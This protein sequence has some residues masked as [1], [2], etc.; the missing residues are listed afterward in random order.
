[1]CDND[2]T[3]G[4][5]TSGCCQA[6]G[7]CGSCGCGGDQPAQPAGDAPA[8]AS[9]AQAVNPLALALA[10]E[11]QFANACARG[12][13]VEETELLFTPLN[14]EAL[15][16]L[17]V[18]LGVEGCD[19]NV[20]VSAFSDDQEY[21]ALL[22]ALY[23]LAVSEG[24]EA[25]QN[26]RALG[27]I[28]G[29]NDFCS[30]THGNGQG[31]TA[32]LPVPGGEEIGQ[33]VARLQVEGD[34]DLIFGSRDWHLWNM[35]N[36]AS[37]NPDKKPYEDTVAD[38]DGQPAVVYPDHCRQR[39]WGA[40]FLPGIRV[41]LIQLLFNKGVS[42]TKDFYSVCGNPWCIRLLKAL[43][44]TDIDLVGLVFRICVGYSAI[45]L[46]RAGFRVRVIVD[47]TRDLDIPAFQEVI[48]EMKRLGVQIITLEQALGAA[49]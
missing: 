43:G 20:L 22:A 32:R 23:Q 47:G 28:D 40:C 5:C 33:P 4:G 21:L 42:R 45:D 1:M 44:I 41:D 46:A 31:E 12:L 10:T 48:E 35:F 14:D 13:D 30:A 26:R 3:G 37:Q 7:V 19:E 34:Y 49:A 25:G 9:Q 16:A 38:E 24:V 2:T 36:F 27:I 8:P 6:D 11:L 39:T 17:R 18:L 29:Q 15:A